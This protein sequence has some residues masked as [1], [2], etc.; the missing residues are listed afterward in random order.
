MGVALKLER[1]LFEDINE[2]NQFVHLGRT[3]FSKQAN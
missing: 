2:L 1:Y 3:S